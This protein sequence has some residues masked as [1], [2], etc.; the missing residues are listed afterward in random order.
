[1]PSN[2]KSKELPSIR[3]STPEQL[4]VFQRE[5]REIL[6]QVQAH[7]DTIDDAVEALEDAQA[8][9]GGGGGGAVTSVSAGSSAVS[10]SPTT[11]AV[12]VDVVESNLA[13][14]PQSAVTSLVVDLASKV[15]VTRSISTTSP[16]SGGGALSSDLTLTVA[17]NSTASKGVVSQAPN[18]TGKFWRGD[19]TWAQPSINGGLLGDGSDG[20]LHF[21]GVS[22]VTGFSRAGSVYTQTRPV[23]ASSITIDSGVTLVLPGGQV[24]CT[25]NTSNAGTVQ[26]DGAAGANSTGTSGAGGAGATGVCYVANGASGGNGGNSGGAPGATGGAVRMPQGTVIGTV[27][28]GTGIGASGGI[29]QGAAGGGSGGSNGGAGGTTSAS[30]TGLQICLANYIQAMT[31]RQPDAQNMAWGSGGGGGRGGSGA[32]GGGGGGGASATGFVW[33]SKSYSGAGAWTAKGGAGGNGSAA[34]SVGT[35]GGGGGGGSGGIVVFAVV[36]GTAPT[37]IVTGGA[38]GAGG[39]G[40]G[41]GAAGSAGG[42]GGSGQFV[43]FNLGT[44]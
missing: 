12:I 7:L 2:T 16:L 43:I 19:A 4:Q 6:R 17:D 28:G 25:G 39:S 21:D 37:P 8:G 34:T 22:S 9:G 32:N 36:N 5:L 26:A 3:D 1:M 29:G 10:V 27:A 13:G 11:G 24:F 44:T 42:T 30:A 20:A 23:F 14:I 18:D 31:L 33:S 35:G 40:N 15:P 38:G 41:G